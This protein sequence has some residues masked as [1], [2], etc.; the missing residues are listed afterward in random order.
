MGQDLFRA[1]LHIHSRHSR[2]TSRSLTPEHLA[3][4]AQIKGLDVVAT[5]DFTHPGWLSELEDALEQD[6]TGLLT[7][8]HPQPAA[9]EI[10]WLQK[11]PPQGRVR[12]MLS[13]EIS[14]IYKRAGKVRK[15]HHLVYVPGLE[16]ARALN[17][18]LAQIGNLSSDGRPILGLDSRHLLE[19]VLLT[20]PL[21][22][23]VPAHI[24]TPWFSLFGSKSG[25]DSI[26]ECYGDLA[27]E[28]FALETGLSSDPDMNWMWSALDRCRLISN[29]DAHSGEKLAREANLFS[30]EPSFEGIY[31]A[32]RGQGLSHKFL[33]TV[34][35]FPEE[36]K[37]HLDGHRKCGVVL[38]PQESI[39]KKNICPVCGQPLTLGVLH[40][41]LELADRDQPQKPL[42][43]P[44]F[45]S[46]VPLT[47]L[48][49]E[50]VG[51]GPGTK[52][53]RQEYARILAA[54]GPELA[55]LGDVPVD[56]LESSH[57]LL[58]EA[59]RRMRQGQ[60]VRQPGYDGHY[61]KISMF[62]SRELDELRHGRL[63]YVPGHGPECI[64]HKSAR[65]LEQSPALPESTQE[66]QHLTFNQEQIQALQAGPHPVLVLAG[67]GTG[68]TRTL[69]GRIV[70]L[71]KRGDHP[72]RLLVVTFTR[73]AAN[74]LRDR[75][76]Y[77]QGEN[78]ALPHADTLHAMAYEFWMRTQGEAPVLLSEDAARR[79]FS[80]AN[81][82]LSTAKMKS[83]WTDLSRARETRNLPEELSEYAQKFSRQKQNW[84]LADYTD[85]LEFWLEQTSGGH[86]PQPYTH[87]LVDE[88]QDLSPLQWELLK[89]LTPG[90][91]NGFWAIG[92]P[93]QSIY[94]FR[95]ALQGL[96]EQLQ[97]QWDNLEIIPLRVNYRSTQNLINVAA[98]L[99]PE[100]PLPQA[101]SVQ[102]G[103][104]S[105]FQ[106]STSGR[107]AAWIGEQIRGLLGGTAHWQADQG[108]RGELGPGD[109]AV[110][111]RMKPLIP[112]IL[113]TLHRMGL[114]SC[115]PEAEP[116]WKEPRIAILLQAASSLLGLGPDKDVSGLH[117][118]EHILV[119][120]PVGL[121]GYLQDVPPF[122]RLFWQSREYL[123]LKEAY[124]K[125]K[126]W[127]GL[128][129]WIHFQSE[130]EL[131]RQRSEKI[132]IMT[133]HAS[134]G[135]EFE[136][137][138]LPALEDG[139]LPMAGLEILGN[140]SMAM[141][142]KTDEAE[143]RRLFYVGMTRAKRL[144]FL[145]HAEKRVLFGRNLRLKPSRFLQG[146]PRE[147]M[148]CS[149]VI[150]QI[151][152]LEKRIPLFPDD[153]CYT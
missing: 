150:H 123:Q 68:K 121:A 78:E 122:D 7:L 118:P 13:A 113:Q 129:S 35:F 141:D 127:T 65:I 71:L 52:K 47:E 138:F 109:I 53:V 57:P 126:G 1:D 49:A 108:L 46:L 98:S 119:Q 63:F 76:L 50:I 137:V 144:L 10:P 87:V 41:V 94:G 37:Y 18:K 84:N 15:V 82:S 115:A 86:F 149:K 91:G 97:A 80:V 31:R 136:A 69:M 89:A 3:A 130:L 153:T 112:Q 95:G 43:S 96:S 75:L 59:L 14:T 8:K 25:F 74:E 64:K 81:P 29:S 17:T 147:D 124:A 105:L 152:R 83:L 40:R 9:V 55:V 90:K 36:G 58:A 79:V 88:A 146:L 116:F 117:C 48:L 70:H 28:I 2:A 114:P 27:S 93:K 21:A 34:E 45:L 16:Q 19:M 61:G 32:L 151:V 100:D 23:L 128:L 4:W 66:A 42:H 120:G 106:A 134:K 51:T 92:D 142:S 102:E 110:L 33:G 139:L 30:G 135:L 26:E 12:F 72:R 133:I 111:V 62:S 143:E 11:S 131:V 20:D 104:I 39:A 140:Q 60:I 5:G 77:I 103:R 85:L 38:D 54:F 99:F 148:H 44:G 73:R 6:E 125:H 107:E 145:S 22:F 24:W 132:Q 56:V 67:P 101:N